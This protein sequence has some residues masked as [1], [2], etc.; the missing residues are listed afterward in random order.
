MKV[1]AI[2]QLFLPLSCF[3]HDSAKRNEEIRKAFTCSF[4]K[5][6]KTQTFLMVND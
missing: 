5:K 2:G 3:E 1:N 4:V 6:T